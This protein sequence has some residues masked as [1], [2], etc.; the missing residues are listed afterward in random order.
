M[1]INTDRL[2]M[3]ALGSDGYMWDPEYSDS[4]QWKTVVN[5]GMNFVRLH[6]QTQLKL[7]HMMTGGRPTCVTSVTAMPWTR[8]AD[9]ITHN[10]GRLHP[11]LRCLAEILFVA[12]LSIRAFNCTYCLLRNPA[13]NDVYNLG[14][15]P[16]ASYPTKHLGVPHY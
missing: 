9:R 13:A 2:N 7:N 4:E 12:V 6:Q 15:R 11:D 14:Q 16:I 5:R 1:K 8:N 3:D 10:Y